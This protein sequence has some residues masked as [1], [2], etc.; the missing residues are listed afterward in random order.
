[1]QQERTGV[2]GFQNATLERMRAG[3]PREAGLA[4]RIAVVPT[5]PRS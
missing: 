2:W 1:M 3:T 4:R 5:G